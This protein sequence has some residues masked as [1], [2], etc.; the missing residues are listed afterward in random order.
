MLETEAAPSSSGTPPRKFLRSQTFKGLHYR[1]FALLWRYDIVKRRHVGAN[2]CAVAAPRSPAHKQ[3]RF[4]AR[5][6]LFCPGSYFLDIFTGRRE[7][8]RPCGQARFL[9]H[10]A[11]KIV[12]AFALAGIPGAILM[13]LLYLIGVGV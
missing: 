12:Y 6:D 9:L 13:I 11:C 10:E 4:S 1:D 8:S 2:Y 5:S 3:L 7:H